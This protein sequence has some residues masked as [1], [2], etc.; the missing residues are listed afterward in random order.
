MK[1][2]CSIT[3]KL[4]CSHA[5]WLIFISDESTAEAIKVLPHFLEII[6]IIIPQN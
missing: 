1:H 4:N 3:V 6:F 2:C 5:H